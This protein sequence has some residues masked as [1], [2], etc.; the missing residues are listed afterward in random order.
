MP[1][2]RQRGFTLIEL[3]IVVAI[4]GIL[5]A[6]AIPAYQDYLARAQ[7]S[8]A[9]ELLG[10]AKVPLVEFYQDVGHWPV[11]AGSLGLNV[12]GNYVVNAVELVTPYSTSQ[13]LLMRATFKTTGIAKQLQGKKMAMTT[14]D[15]GLHWRCGPDPTA[16]ADAVDVRYLPQACR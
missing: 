12:E 16:G 5:A 15:G 9:L 11:S 6:V 2:R 4:I 14:S 8:E 13:E 1:H 7:A 3:M 10:G